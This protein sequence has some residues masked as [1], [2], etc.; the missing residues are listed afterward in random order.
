MTYDLTSQ[1]FGRLKVIEA[2]GSF[3]GKRLWKC[4]CVCGET[5]T[6]RSQYLR[7]GR[8][9]SCGCLG[10]ER[11]LEACTTHGMTGAKEYRA[12]QNMMTRCYNQ[13]RSYYKDY[14]GRG[15]RV[16]KAWQKSFV[17]FYDHIGPAPT[18]K[19]TV[20][21]IRNAEGYK[22]GNVRWATRKE[23]RYNQ[24]P[25]GKD[26]KANGKTNAQATAKASSTGTKV[27]RR[28]GRR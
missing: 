5:T 10:K 27:A 16:C 4:K 15:I 23:Q 2:S 17:A 24:R 11:R 6:V 26:K 20:D 25:T 3:Q 19:H 7:D 12:W 9:K 18:R 22:P 28:T 13:N 21:R 1:S 8:T 14:G